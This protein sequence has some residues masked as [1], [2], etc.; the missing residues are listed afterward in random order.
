MKSAAFG[1]A[2]QTT[3]SNDDKKAA[4]W[5]AKIAADAAKDNIAAS[6]MKQEIERK[7]WGLDVVVAPDQLRNMSDP[8]QADR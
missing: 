2:A 8:S 6:K 5:R 4:W 3:G 1:T 7:A